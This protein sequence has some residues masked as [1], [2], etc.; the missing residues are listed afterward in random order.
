MNPIRWTL[1]NVFLGRPLGVFP[2]DIVQVF[3]EGDTSAF[4]I[5]ILNI[6]EHQRQRNN[7]AEAID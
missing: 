3:I 4:S 2:G 6:Y 5:L 7:Q 1:E